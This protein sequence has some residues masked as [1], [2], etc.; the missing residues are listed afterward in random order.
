MNNHK[1]YGQWGRYHATLTT[2]T[3]HTG[4]RTH[5]LLGKSSLRGTEFYLG[6]NKQDIVN[7]IDSL[8][9]ILEK[10]RRDTNNE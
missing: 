1:D 5:L 2:F 3:Y 6:D 10:I 7:T 9:W 4:P 8:I